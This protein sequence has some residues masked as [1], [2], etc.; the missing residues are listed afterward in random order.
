MMNGKGIHPHKG[1]LHEAMEE[2]REFTHPPHKM[3]NARGGEMSTRELQPNNKYTHDNSNSTHDQ[4]PNHKLPPLEYPPQ[5]MC[6]HHNAS[7]RHLFSKYNINFPS[8]AQTQEESKII[9]QTKLIKKLKHMVHSLKQENESL[10]QSNNGDNSE[11]VCNHHTRLFFSSTH[12]K[13]RRRSCI[14]IYN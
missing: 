2:E 6:I 10:K 8:D 4:Q 7:A 13:E 14:S 12:K 5:G 9:E 11:K 3:K 1:H